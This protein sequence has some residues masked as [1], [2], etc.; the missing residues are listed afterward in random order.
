RYR[1][2]RTDE[3][4]VRLIAAIFPQG[5]KSWVFKLQGPESEVSLRTDAFTD[6]VRSVHFDA[7]A[8]PPVTWKLPDG[9]RRD[10]ERPD[11][12]A[13]LRLGA[14]DDALELTVSQ[15]T[16]PAASNILAN[17]NRWRGQLGLRPIADAALVQVTKKL[18][19]EGN[20]AVIVD[21]AG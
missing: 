11:R 9:W 19:V 18:T 17:V 3:P 16:G 21:M 6:F 15:L 10:A 14:K 5:E 7:K 13:T 12:F 8:D 20:E 2:P 1:A 4:T